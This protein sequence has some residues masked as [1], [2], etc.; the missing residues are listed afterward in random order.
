MVWGGFLLCT[1]TSTRGEIHP[2]EEV[3]VLRGNSRSSVINTQLMKGQH[4]ELCLGL[5]KL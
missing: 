2:G 1:L 5:S 4:T 3:V